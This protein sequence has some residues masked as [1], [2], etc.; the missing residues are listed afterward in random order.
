[1][2]TAIPQ[3]QL[4]PAYEGGAKLKLGDRGQHILNLAGFYYDYKDLQND[5]LLNPVMGAQT[6]NA[7]RARIYGLEA[8][9]TLHPSSNDT[10]TGSV[11]LLHAS[12]KE[13]LA[14]VAAYTI[15]NAPA[16]P[17]TTNLAG[18]RLPQTPRIVVTLGYDHVFHIGQA[19]TITASAFS[20]Y[21]GDYYLDFYNY[22]DSRQS[23][24]SQTD[25]S[26]EYRPENRKFSVQ[27]FVRNLENYRSIAYAGNTVV[28]GVANI[29]NWQFTP[30]RTY[31]IR[32]GIDF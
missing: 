3:L 21:K 13:F 28:P 8:E 27:A 16:T 25:L 30:P 31:G 4:G 12:Y 23:A 29:Y 32:L 26:L 6:F 2:L 22:H 1:V 15:G 20:R 24:H 19:G 5:V 7:G 11:N 10:I 9:A 18:N 17:T 14:S